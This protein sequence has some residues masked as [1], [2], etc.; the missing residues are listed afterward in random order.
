[1]NTHRVK[2]MWLNEYEILRFEEDA[3]FSRYG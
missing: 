3:T 2:E 1:M